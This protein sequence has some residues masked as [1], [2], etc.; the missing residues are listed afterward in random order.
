DRSDQWHIAAVECN[1]RLAA[2][3]RLRMTT[4][5]VL[6]EFLGKSAKQP[7]RSV[8]ATAVHRLVSQARVEVIV[9][10]H[11]DWQRG[12]AL[13]EARLDKDWSL[14]DCLSILVCKDRGIKD[15]FTGDRHFQQARLRILL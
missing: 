6:T 15:V 12:L 4:E 11:D 7:L 5:W 10:T 14:V 1:Q 8:A 2:S 9:A 3:K 13:Y